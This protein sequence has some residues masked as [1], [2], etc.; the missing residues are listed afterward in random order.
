MSHATETDTVKLDMFINVNQKIKE[1]LFLA[2][3][4]VAVH[5]LKNIICNP[6]YRTVL[7]QHLDN[8]PLSSIMLLHWIRMQIAV[9]RAARRADKLGRKVNLL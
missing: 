6:R 8:L 5:M 1:E 9:F 3:Q 4:S 2:E 7:N